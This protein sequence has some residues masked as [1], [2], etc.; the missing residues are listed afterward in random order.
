MTRTVP[1]LVGAA[2]TV[3]QGQLVIENSKT[4]ATEITV[5][6][7]FKITVEEALRYTGIFVEYTIDI[8]GYENA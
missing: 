8:D 2:C 6:T 5:P 3:D 1:I 7:N 4:L